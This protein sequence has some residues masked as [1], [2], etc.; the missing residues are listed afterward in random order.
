MRKFTD[1]FDD[2]VGCMKTSN[3]ILH[4]W[5]DAWPVR[6][7]RQSKVLLK[8]K[9]NMVGIIETHVVVWLADYI[10]IRTAPSY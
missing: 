4:F 5:L 2:F 7:A 3:Q 8:G 6:S 9:N 10:M 1:C